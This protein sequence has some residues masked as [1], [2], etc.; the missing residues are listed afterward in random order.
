MKFVVAPAITDASSNDLEAT[1]SAFVTR[2][3]CAV[4]LLLARFGSS[5]VVVTV[6]VLSATEVASVRMKP[7][8]VR[9]IEPPTARSS[10][11]EQAIRFVMSS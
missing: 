5:S 1:R 8:T 9:A 4:P 2:E 7:V 10:V 11:N 6:A 3:A